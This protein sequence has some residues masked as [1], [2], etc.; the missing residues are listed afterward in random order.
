VSVNTSDSWCRLLIGLNQTQ[1]FVDPIDFIGLPL[2]QNTHA[3]NKQGQLSLM[4]WFNTSGFVEDCTFYLSPQNDVKIEHLELMNAGFQMHDLYYSY[5][6]G[7]SFSLSNVTKGNRQMV[8]NTVV[9]SLHGAIGL[10]VSAILTR[11]SIPVECYLDGSRVVANEAAVAYYHIDDYEFSFAEDSFYFYGE[12]STYCLNFTAPKDF[13]LRVDASSREEI[14]YIIF[15][16][17]PQDFSVIQTTTLDEPCY[18]FTFKASSAFNCCL[19]LS[20]KRKGWFI[21]PENMS[22]TSIPLNI[23]DR[24]LNPLSSPDG[25]YFDTNTIF[26]QQWARQ[27]TNNETNPYIIAFSIFQN[28]TKTLHYPSDW[29]TLEQKNAFNESVSQVLK[30][31]NAVCRHFARAY[32]A[33]SICSGLPA[34]TV[35]GTGFGLL[36]ETWKKN[37]EWVEVYF[38]GYGWVTIDPAW[39]QFCILSE[40]HAKVTY[41]NYVE[42]SL[43]VTS[44]ENTFRTRAKASSK[45][46]M[47]YLIQS[48]RTQLKHKS[49]EIEESEVL[50]DQASTLAASGS[51][52]EALLYVARAY[53]LIA[54][55]SSSP[56]LN[57]NEPVYIIVLGLVILSVALVSEFRKSDQSLLRREEDLETFSPDDI[58]NRKIEYH[59]LNEIIKTRENSTIIVGSILSA[60]SFLILAVAF[61]VT[62][63]ETRFFAILISVLLQGIWLCYYHATSR[64]DNLCY[65]LLRKLERRLRIQVHI[66]LRSHQEK[67]LITKARKYVWLAIFIT[68]WVTGILILICWH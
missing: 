4:F 39:G 25:N 56:Q 45:N 15:D 51:V 49:L 55:A 33:L 24:Y 29:R 6:G 8:I 42:D 50:L 67:S 58:E 54:G 65:D 59:T 21:S 57:R 46:L 37:H 3:I 44:I 68:I 7:A 5:S 53:V 48:C 38:P 27:L 22:L 2:G 30:S 16:T 66:Y 47:S 17:F 40:G 14:D 13:F 18:Q 35:I 32:T 9:N 1:E 19:G 63:E 61:Q 31:G 64:L 11:L 34:R 26:V 23:K 36:N 43:N 28:I 62:S 12:E 41:W 10:E 52:H 20:L 60:A